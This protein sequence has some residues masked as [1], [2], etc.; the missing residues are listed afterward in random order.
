[1][2][3]LVLEEGCK[4]PKSIHEIVPDDVQIWS[5]RSGLN[6]FENERVGRPWG[7]W[8]SSRTLRRE[9]Q[10]TRVCRR[11][12]GGG[13]KEVSL[14]RNAAY[15]LIPGTHCPVVPSWRVSFRTEIRK[16]I[17]WW[18]TRIIFPFV[19]AMTGSS[20]VNR[21]VGPWS[22]GSWRPGGRLGH[23][24]WGKIGSSIMIRVMGPWSG[25]SWRPREVWPVPSTNQLA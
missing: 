3:P 9:S 20:I 7:Q 18:C 11:R 4:P 19:R 16:T 10:D 13:R 8:V 24:D 15:P 5:T 6:G 23:G 25:V 1:M 12:K 14:L 22:G 2:W 21:V 17:L